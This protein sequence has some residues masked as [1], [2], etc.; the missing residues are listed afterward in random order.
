[1]DGHFILSSHFQDILTFPKK[2]TYIPRG[3][4]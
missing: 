2:L 4:K 1:M 3:D